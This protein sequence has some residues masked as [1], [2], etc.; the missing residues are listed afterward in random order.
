MGIYERVKNG[1][2]PIYRME[3]TTPLSVF[4]Y[5]LTVD[6]GTS[7]C[8]VQ[9]PWASSPVGTGGVRVYCSAG[10]GSKSGLLLQQIKLSS[11]G[12]CY[13]KKPQSRKSKKVRGLPTVQQKA[14]THSH[15]LGDRKERRPPSRE[16]PLPRA[17]HERCSLFWWDFL[18]YEFQK[19]FLFIYLFKF[20][21]LLLSFSILF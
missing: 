19:N 15:Q 9:W 7:G 3:I 2:A 17:V 10:A 16:R 12:V 8:W 5:H 11:F 14:G 1:R 6:L 4:H 18:K 21:K 20:Y 13:V